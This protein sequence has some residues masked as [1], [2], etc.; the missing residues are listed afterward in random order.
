MEQNTWAN[1]F[2][3]CN[4]LIDY[5]ILSGADIQTISRSIRQLEIDL[6]SLEPVN[7]IPDISP[8]IL[9]RVPQV[10][11]PEYQFPLSINDLAFI[12]GFKISKIFK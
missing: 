11:R 10:D 4:P 6:S 1:A 3:K 8:N 12:N 5:F 9:W 7:A 2:N